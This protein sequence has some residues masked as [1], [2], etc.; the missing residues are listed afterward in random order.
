MLLG[1]TNN[2][3]DLNSDCE[4]LRNCLKMVEKSQKESREPLV[5]QH[6]VIS[7]KMIQMFAVIRDCFLSF[8]WNDAFRVL[9]SIIRH[10]IMKNGLTV[11]R[12]SFELFDKLSLQLT[13]NNNSLITLSSKLSLLSDIR[14]KQI[15][16]DQFLLSAAQLPDKFDWN[17]VLVQLKTAISYSKDNDKSKKRSMRSK[18]DEMVE[19]CL[20]FGYG[21]VIL[22][23]ECILRRRALSSWT[24]EQESVEELVQ[25]LV[26]T[27][28]SAIQGF[29]EFN[30]KCKNE[31]GCWDIFFSK[32]VELLEYK[33]QLVPNE[34]SACLEKAEKV[35]KNYV[36]Q[37]PLNPNAWRLLYDFYCRNAYDQ[38]ERIRVLQELCTFVPSDKLV[39]ELCKFSSDGKVFLRRKSNPIVFLFNYL[40]YNQLKSSAWQMFAEILVTQSTQSPDSEDYA[41]LVDSVR[42]CWLE[43]DRHSWWPAYQFSLTQLVDTSTEEYE[44][45]SFKAVVA[46]FLLGPKNEFTSKVKSTLRKVPHK[47]YGSSLLKQVKH[48]PSLFPLQECS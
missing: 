32:H 27:V 35:L 7:Y 23:S 18:W 43:E 30:L 11:L 29:D 4:E 34:K 21:A 46:R 19:N 39:L 8:R 28:D 1:T 24:S 41:F 15:S 14:V 47:F 13:D 12:L 17:S 31:P 45:L 2:E 20:I 25:V 5:C 6:K 33:S 10:P 9:R 3:E 40:D 48:M 22:Y 36:N 37:H 38:E 44:I 26:S 42:D 16:L